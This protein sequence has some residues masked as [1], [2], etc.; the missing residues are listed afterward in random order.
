MAKKSARKVAARKAH[1][2]KKKKAVRAGAIKALPKATTARPVKPKAPQLRS[3]H[4]ATATEGEKPQLAGWTTSAARNRAPHVRRDFAVALAKGMARKPAKAGE[5]WLNVRPDPIDF[6]DAPYV[7]TLVEVKPFIDPPQIDSRL[8]RS[9]GNEGA[10]TG[11]AL[12]AAIDIQNWVRRARFSQKLAPGEID[13][14]VPERVSARMLYEMARTYDEY[15]DDG[16]QGSSVRGAIKAFFHNG[17]CSEEAA[18]YRENDTGWRL[19][20]DRAKEARRTS[21]GAYFRL[22]HVLYDYHAALSEVDTVYCSAVVHQNWFKP[23]DGHILLPER[24]KLKIE[25]AHAFALVGYDA[26]GFYVLNSWGA[27]WGGSAHGPGIAHWSYED[28]QEHIM[29]AWALRL[30]VPSE[31]TFHTVGGRGTNRARDARGKAVSIPRIEVNGHY[32]HVKD[33]RYVTSGNYWNN[34]ASFEETAA[35]LAKKPEPDS[36]E[37]VYKHLLFYA[38]GGL[39][40]VDDAVQR[41]HTM[42]PVLKQRDI[43]PVFF[44]WRTGFWEELLDVLRGREGRVAARVEEISDLSDMLLEGIAQPIVRPIWREM[45]EDAKDAMTVTPPLQN[46]TGAGWE[47]TRILLGAALQAGM[48]LHFVGHSAGAILLGQLLMRARADKVALG[49]ALGSISL[50]A[51]ACTREFFD[52]VT[53]ALPNVGGSNTDFAIY[54]LSNRFER[55]DT[56]GTIY[57]KSLLYLVSN[58]FEETPEAPLAGFEAVA[59]EIVKTNK[60]VALHISDGKSAATQSRTHGGFDNDPATLNHI[61]NR[62]LGVPAGT[63]GPGKGGFDSSML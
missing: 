6:R 33:G 25:G 3:A 23:Q 17:V 38:H 60:K 18:P 37:R 58:S 20:V 46:P 40:D 39:N 48:K 7:P 47:A 54:N 27:D 56:V 11:H 15:P 51:P 9:Q 63:F 14:L 29:D 50:M 53:A 28:W 42:I 1:T 19:T 10:C 55:D 22:R 36:K 30:A 62:V 32:I 24:D 61:L 8:I 21:L 57:R 43:Y 4:T 5:P 41:A 31:K 44:I 26:N 35:R 12:A 2:R 45:K 16:L 49:N 59:K 34:K 13:K 52:D